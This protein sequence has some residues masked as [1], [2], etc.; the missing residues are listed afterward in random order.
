VGADTFGNMPSI[1]RCIAFGY[2]WIW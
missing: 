2:C 1:K